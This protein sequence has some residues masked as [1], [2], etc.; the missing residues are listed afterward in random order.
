MILRNGKVVRPVTVKMVKRRE[1]LNYCVPFIMWIG[2]WV[3][4]SC[5]FGVC[6]GFEKFST[7]P[8]VNVT[9]VTLGDAWS[10][11]RPYVVSPPY[12]SVLARVRPDL[13]PH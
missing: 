8:V 13:I 12:L 3:G 9:R 5:L 6:G 2:L 1:S 7:N 10:V 11:V 4:L